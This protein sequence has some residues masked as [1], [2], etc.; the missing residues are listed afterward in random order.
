MFKNSEEEEVSCLYVFPKVL[1]MKIVAESLH[2]KE[3]IATE[4][5]QWLKADCEKIKVPLSLPDRSLKVRSLLSMHIFLSN[6]R[7]ER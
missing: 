5:F 6:K 2:F 1:R 3:Y 7:V 4:T